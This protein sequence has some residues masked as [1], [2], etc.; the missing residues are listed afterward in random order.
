MCIRRGDPSLLDEEF[1]FVLRDKIAGSGRHLPKIGS[2]VIVERSI[3]ADL[4]KKRGSTLGFNVPGLCSGFQ[5]FMG[6]VYVRIYMVALRG[7]IGHS[8]EFLTEMDAEILKVGPVGPG[9]SAEN[10][11]FLGRKKVRTLNSNLV[12]LGGRRT[13]PKR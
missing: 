8:I 7:E 9:K 1:Y 2:F 4:V 10:I 6:H 12:Q 3:Q 5:V 13:V 11:V